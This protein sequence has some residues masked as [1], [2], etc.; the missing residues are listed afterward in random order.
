[1]AMNTDFTSCSPGPAEML[2]SFLA[3]SIS[4]GKLTGA[5]LESVVAW[6]SR[7]IQGVSQSRDHGCHTGQMQQ[8]LQREDMEMASGPQHT[9]QSRSAESLLPSPHRSLTSAV[10]QLSWL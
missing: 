4:W 3:Q 6:T 8:H 5:Q 10:E 9:R 2:C 1:M 7:A